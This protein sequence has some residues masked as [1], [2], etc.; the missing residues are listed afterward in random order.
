MVCVC[1]CKGKKR[2][3]KDILFDRKKKKTN[4][5]LSSLSKEKGTKFKIESK[6]RKEKNKWK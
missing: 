6:D 5:W 2:E 1:V 3:V 4:N